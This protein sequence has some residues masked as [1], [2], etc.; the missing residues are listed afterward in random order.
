MKN[1]FLGIICLIYSA[2]IIYVWTFDLI[3]SFLAPNMQIYLKLSLIPMLILGIVF[4]F[5]INYKFKISDLVLLLP[6]IMLIMAGDGNL[7][8]GFA[9]SRMTSISN[10]LEKREKAEDIQSQVPVDYEIVKKDDKEKEIKVEDNPF[11]DGYYFDI[12]DPV[13]SYLADYITYMSGARVFDGKTIRFR[14]FAVDYSE[15][16]QDGYF[17]LGKYAI[18]CCAADAE[19]TG[20]MVRYDLSKIK[21]GNWY[22]VEGVLKE[23]IDSEGYTIMTVEAINVKEISSKK[24][25]QYVYSCYSYGED[26][27]LELLKYD[28]TY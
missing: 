14:G 16:L 5:K 15:Y 8:I 27:C 2:I 10:K 22:E 11:E 21:Y 28:L 12:K 13:Y 18:T 20:F 25:E 19:F 3:N 26:K 6:V 17:A 1:R 9:Q 7:S 23:G 4:C 24:E